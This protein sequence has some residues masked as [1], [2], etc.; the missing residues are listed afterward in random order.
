MND[1]KIREVFGAF[2][3]LTSVAVM[4]DS[5]GKS[6]CFG[7]VNFAEHEHAV[8][9]IDALHMKYQTPGG[10]GLF[11]GKA[12][13]KSER[14]AEMRQK[15]EA[16]RSKPEY[17]GINLYVKNLDDDIDDEKLRNEFGRFGSITSVKVM[18]DDKGHSKGFGF[19]CFRSHEEASRAMNEMKGKQIGTKSLYVAI[20]QRKD[21]NLQRGQH[22]DRQDAMMQQ[23]YYHPQGFKQVQRGGQRYGQNY[24]HRGQRQQSRRYENRRYNARTNHSQQ[25]A[26]QATSAPTPAHDLPENTPP[27]STPTDSTQKASFLADVPPEQHMAVLGEQLF[28]LIEKDNSQD[29]PKIT[30]MLLDRFSKDELISFLQDPVILKE[31]VLEA[32]QVL[33]QAETASSEQS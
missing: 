10:K 19:V 31:K 17:H 15:Y 22:Y 3:P 7:F 9:A 32:V 5:E 4:V 14:D 1:E 29:A 2:G 25:P 18:R 23:N 13:K 8:A 30:G 20:A 16:N 26:A 24:Q 21:T 27:S 12:M 28:H 11:V 6:K 33:R